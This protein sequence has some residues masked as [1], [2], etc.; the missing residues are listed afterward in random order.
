MLGSWHHD[1]EFADAT[2]QSRTCLGN[3]H[4]MHSQWYG[5]TLKCTHNPQIGLSTGI[6]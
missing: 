4:D 1:S 5:V 3:V 6:T 2:I